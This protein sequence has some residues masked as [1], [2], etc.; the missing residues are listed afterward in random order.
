MSRVYGAGGTPPIQRGLVSRAGSIV[1]YGGDFSAHH[2]QRI[3]SDVNATVASD[4]ISDI[5]SQIVQQTVV[6]LDIVNRRPCRSHQQSMPAGVPNDDVIQHYNIPKFRARRGGFDSDK[7]IPRNV[8]NVQVLKF[9]VQT[10]V[11]LDSVLRSVGSALPP[12]ASIYG[13]A[14]DPDSFHAILGRGQIRNLQYRAA[15]HIAVQR[16]SVTLK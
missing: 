8:L 3:S 11:Q 9:H 13:K 16:G 6:K 5:C 14:F 10:C 4:G 1:A 2:G 12:P 7:R 15:L